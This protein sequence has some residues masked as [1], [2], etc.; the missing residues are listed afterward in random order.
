MPPPPAPG[1]APAKPSTAA[2][3]SSSSSSQEDAAL[4]APIGPQQ[5]ERFFC[6]I[7][8]CNLNSSVQMQ[9]VGTQCG[10]IQSLTISIDVLMSVKNII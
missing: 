3:C 6:E 10:I 8:N 1:A 5:P 4:A 2:A 7:C 9:Q